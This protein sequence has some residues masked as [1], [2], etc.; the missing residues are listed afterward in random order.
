MESRE[1]GASIT[2]H[3]V[4]L[5]CILYEGIHED[6]G[7]VLFGSETLHELTLIALNE[8]RVRPCRLLSVVLCPRSP[9]LSSSSPVS[10]VAW[11]HRQ[12]LGPALCSWEQMRRF[13]YCLLR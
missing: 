1:R 5:L 11:S 13:L 2:A 7:Q 12:R 8:L 6:D 9:A 3:D 10:L 4:A